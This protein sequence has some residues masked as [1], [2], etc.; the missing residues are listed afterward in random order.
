V[1]HASRWRLALNQAFLITWAIV[2]LLP[3]IWMFSASLQT[4]Q[5]IYAGLKLI[6]TAPQWSNYSQAWSMSDF[7]TYF[8]N[9]LFYTVATV[10]GTIL[11]SSMAAFGFAW[12]KIPG[13][14]IFYYA[15]LFLLM[16]PI[17]GQFVPLFLVLVKLGLADTRLGYVLVLIN[18]SLAVSIFLLRGYMESVPK[19]LEEAARI[20]GASTLML[21]WR[22]MMPLCRPALATITIFTALS[23][24]NELVLALIIFSDRSKLPVQAGLMI[25]QGTYLTRFDLMMAATTIAT[26]PVILM[27]VVAQRSIIKSVMAGAVKG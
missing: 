5:E 14:E 9:S 19:A 26:I 17:P 27:Y 8:M 7:G 2:S 20:D 13:K 23:A 18:S 24:W 22:I 3:L 1:Y 6:P 25:F 21:Y 10:V 15:F 4:N 11:I 12:L 16:M